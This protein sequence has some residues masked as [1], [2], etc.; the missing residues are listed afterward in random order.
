VR[1]G[2]LA[3][4]IVLL[5]LVLFAACAGDGGSAGAIGSAEVNLQI[6]HP[7]SGVAW[8][9][10]PVDRVDYRITCP[11][12]FP[13][14]VAIPPADTSGTIYGYDDSVDMSGVFEIIDTQTPPVWQ[15][16]MDLPPGLCTMT[17]SVWDGDEITCLGTQTMTILEGTAVKYDIT[18]VCSLS[19]DTP[20]GSLNI[21]SSL[22]FNDGNY[23][24][25]L[26][27]IGAD[28]TTFGPMD[29]PITNLEM[30]AFDPDTSC[31]LN[32]DPQTCD[33]SMNPPVCTPAADPGM[34]STFFTTRGGGVGTFGDVNASQTTYICSPLY[35][36][37]TDL[38]VLVSDGDIECDKLGCVTIVCP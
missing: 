12:S 28:P 34:I 7:S 1:L 2:G 23:C 25:M 14:S 26:I 3:R 36:G 33:N 8:E 11:G 15:A 13:G 24:P 19:V 5:G 27:W 16:T 32:C 20:E 10:F 22:T 18:L 17:L 30:Y 37:P 29:G 6:V 9:G 31:G 35:P 21:D 4:S 38:C